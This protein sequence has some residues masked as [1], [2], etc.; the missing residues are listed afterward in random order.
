MYEA[1]MSL[2]IAAQI[3][4]LWKMDRVLGWRPAAA[5]QNWRWR[6]LWAGT[7]LRLQRPSRKGAILAIALAAQ[8]FVDVGTSYADVPFTTF[9]F[10]GT[11]SPTSRTTPDRIADSIN[12]KEHGAVGDGSTDDTAAIQ[13]AFN[14]AAQIY[15]GTIYFPANASGKYYKTTAPINLRAN[16]ALSYV[17]RGDGTASSIRGSF[18]GFIF[19]DALY[20][21]TV[22]S[23]RTIGANGDG[24]VT[25]L[26][27]FTGNITSDGVLHLTAALTGTLVLGYQ[28]IFDGTVPQGTQVAQLLSG[29]LGV[30]GST[31]SLVNFSPTGGVKVIEKLDIQNSDNTGP[32]SGCI[33]IANAIGGTCKDLTLNGYVNIQGDTGADNPLSCSLSLTLINCIISTANA[34]AGSIGFKVGGNSSIIGC[35]CTTRDCGIQMY[36]VANN[37]IGGRYEVNGTGLA[38]TGPTNFGIISTQPFGQAEGLIAGASFESCST[39]IDF[40]QG[41]GVTIQNVHILAFNGATPGGGNPSYGIRIRAGKSTFSTFI[42][43]NIG[44]VYAQGGMFIADDGSADFNTFINCQASSTGVGPG[45][46]MPTHAS[47]ATFINSN[48]PAPIYTF[49]NL[50]SSPTESD[51]YMISDSPIAASG[52]FAAN[53]T[54]GGGSNQVLVRWNGSHW[55]IASG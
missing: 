24:G 26:A 12:V 2:A 19:D 22:V 16:G 5:A 17:L 28:L 11:G 25:P 4:L 42:G 55:T 43:V 23:S 6:L 41:S 38:F 21:G 47:V 30:A 7:M 10:P 14:K 27:T 32:Y 54:V 15:A 13:A 40:M 35:E 39:A 49:A 1:L 31:Y 8:A 29:S 53:V 37:V 51:A 46:S 18:N 45:W 34:P 48:N 9:A 36:G 44:G 20:N 33:R 3:L 50:P 52:N